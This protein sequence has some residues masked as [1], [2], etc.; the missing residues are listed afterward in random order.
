[1]ISYAENDKLKFFI[2]KMRKIEFLE[3]LSLLSSMC[4]SFHQPMK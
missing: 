4:K 3:N 1:M 2:A